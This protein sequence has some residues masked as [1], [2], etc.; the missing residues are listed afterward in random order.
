MA[1]SFRTQ[2]ALRAWLEQHHASEAELMMRLYKVHARSKG[3]GYREALDECLCYGWIDG[4]RRALDADSFTQRFTPRTARSNWSAVNVKRMSAL[5]A[6]GR[7]RP[8][9]LAAFEKRGKTG[10]APYSFENRGIELD[11][12]F[13][14][15]FKAEPKAWAYY[16][17]LPPGYQRLMIFRVMQA[18]REETRERRFLSLLEWCRK[19]QRMPLT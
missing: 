18:K 15:R 4:V 3:I 8:S 6:E 16:E 19:G 1:K 17:A 9:G 12:A 10:P 2:K 7:V 14:K 11:A 13:V 5:I